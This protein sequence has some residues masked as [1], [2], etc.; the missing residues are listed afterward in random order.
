MSAETAS[1]LRDLCCQFE[2]WAREA[3]DESSRS[4]DNLGDAFYA[5]VQDA[6]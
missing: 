1:E 6:V 2:L 5:S 4:W 3:L